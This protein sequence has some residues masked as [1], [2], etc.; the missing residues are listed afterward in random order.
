MSLR[1]LASG[2]ATVHHSKSSKRFSPYVS[3]SFDFSFDLHVVAVFLMISS[4]QIDLNYTNVFI[5]M[6]CKVK[7]SKS[8][9]TKYV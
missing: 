5:N 6:V 9:I 1:L 2:G 3:A 4:R 8:K 7:K